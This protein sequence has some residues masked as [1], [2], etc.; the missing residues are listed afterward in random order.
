MKR[1]EIANIQSPFLTCTPIAYRIIGG[2][3]D[4]YSSPH[5]K[6][7]TRNT[8]LNTQ[9]LLMPGVELVTSDKR[10]G[11]WFSE[12]KNLILHRKCVLWP[13]PA[14]LIPYDGSIITSSGRY[15]R[16][17]KGRSFREFTGRTYSSFLSAIS[18]ASLDYTETVIDMSFQ[19][20]TNYWHLL[21]DVLG[22][23]HLLREA[24][25]EVEKYPLIISDRGSRR[26]FFKQIA[27]MP[28][29]RDLKWIPEQNPVR[30]K[31]ILYCY[32]SCFN[33]DHYLAMQRGFGFHSDGMGGKRLFAARS[34][35]K[36]GLKRIADNDQEIRSAL[37]KVGF[38]TI[39]CGEIPVEEQWKLFQNAEIIVG[40]H[41]ADLGNAMF[42]REGSVKVL[43]LFVEYGGPHYWN[44]CRLLNQEYRL[45]SVPQRE[46]GVFTA[47][48]PD[49]LDLLFDWL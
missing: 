21:D 16:Y 1:A 28:M 23:L 41:G 11:A 47:S 20:T 24:G 42:C 12:W 22:K 27:G 31:Q 33:R 10:V 13:H 15:V 40:Y 43:E 30:C 4:I 17:S 6:A 37:E 9:E 7:E 26:D 35:S 25:I 8:L 46:N 3:W 34:N 49:L 2:I 32:D 38:T 14:L 29:F 36:L 18:Q 5:Q 39:Y 19:D 44:L 45:Y 48:I